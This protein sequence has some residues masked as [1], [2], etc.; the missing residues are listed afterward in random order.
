MLLAALALVACGTTSPSVK[1]I[2]FSERTRDHAIFLEQQGDIV[3][4]LYQRRVL[5][6]MNPDDA[7]ARAETY[8]LNQLIELRLSQ[9]EK[10]FS[11]AGAQ[12]SSVR[13]R[14][15]ALK[16]LMLDG[17]HAAALDY[18]REQDRGN[19]LESQSLKDREALRAL[20]LR[21]KKVEQQLEE[22]ELQK[23]N[24]IAERTQKQLIK[25]RKADALF[26]EGLKALSEDLDSAIALLT[27]SLRYDPG[28]RQVNMQLQRA[29]KMQITLRKIEQK[30]KVTKKLA[31]E[32]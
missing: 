15:V 20:A 1:R 17:R 13:Q 24:E 30:K 12:G 2:E 29:K 32:S 3:G 26:R 11:L 28:N 8:R 23:K 9:L 27:E 19:A 4:A 16:L 10:D 6:A 5:Y 21:R 25:K 22:H 14:L 7:K 31:P 18:L